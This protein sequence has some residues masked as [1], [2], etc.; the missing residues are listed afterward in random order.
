MNDPLVKLMSSLNFLNSTSD[1]LDALISNNSII[2]GR[3]T[4]FA[5][6][7]KCLW[8]S[9]FIVKLQAVVARVVSLRIVEN[10]SIWDFDEK[11]TP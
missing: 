6:P 10:F 3:G 1:H 11:G 8:E 9:F 5:F 2:L 7:G 4:V